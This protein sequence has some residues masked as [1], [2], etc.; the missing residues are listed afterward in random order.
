MSFTAQCL[1]APVLLFALAANAAPA[2]PEIVQ[3]SHVTARPADDGVVTV[4]FETDE[5]YGVAVLDARLSQGT[6][7]AQVR[8]TMEP[9][10]RPGMRG[11]IGLAFHVSDDAENYEVIYIR[12]RNAR[13]E[14]QIF[15]NRSVQYA[16]HPDHPWKRLR[17]E[18]PGVYET[19]VDLELGAWTDLR[20]EVGEDD[21]RFYVGDAEQPTLIVS[22]LILRAR[23]GRVGLWIGEGTIGEFR[24][25]RVTPTGAGQSSSS[26]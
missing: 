16:A 21:A 10:A 20:I 19:Y 18:S 4:R 3:T 5:T 24:N 14:Q 23:D 13:V 9:D 15:R 1:A 2:Q 22:D 25:I 11:F 26:S 6:I 12:P 17:E 7:E 8:S